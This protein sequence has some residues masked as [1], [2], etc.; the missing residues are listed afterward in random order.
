M[1]EFVSERCAGAD[2]ISFS[3]FL[4][5]VLKVR[6]VSMQERQTELLKLFQNTDSDRSG[7]QSL[8]ECSRVLAQMGLCPRTRA[9][10]RQIGNLFD[11]ADQDGSGQLDF[12]EFSD[13]FQHV[14]E[15]L[16]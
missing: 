5:L 6:K 10:Q 11:V 13:L 2:T 14:H 16:Q 3:L 12:E 8:A 1:K 7:L 15:L 9:Q 4:E